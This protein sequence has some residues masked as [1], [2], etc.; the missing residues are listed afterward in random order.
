MHRSLVPALL[1]ALCACSPKHL[2]INSAADALTG[3]EGGG[4]GTDDDP[5]LVGAA[6]PFALKTIESLIGVEPENP[7]LLLAGCSGFTQYAYAF[8]DVPAQTNP[9]LKADEVA[10]AHARAMKLLARGHAYCRR[11]L[12]ARHEGFGAAYAKDATAALKMTDDQD[13]V[14]L[15][16]WSAAS[17]A[18]QVAGQKDNPQFLAQLPEVGGF[19]ERALALDAGWD[20]GSIHELLEAYEAS[21]PAAMGGSVE[22]AQA[23]RDAAL[24]ASENK[25]LG[26]HV[27]WAEDV[28]VAKQDKAEFKKILDQV[29]AFD[30]DSAPQYRLANVLAQRRARWLLAHT[31]DLF[32]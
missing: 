24:K 26:P 13:D 9:S 21:R 5:E 25:K 30:V 6:T 14:P 11:G 18:L 3:G 12:E 2:I 31:D 28:A 15:L 19:A 17:L 29:L 4:W 1:L 20:H 8:L 10:F 22:K 27:T 7:K 16:Y 23:H 32:V